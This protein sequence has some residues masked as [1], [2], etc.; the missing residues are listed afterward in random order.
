MISLVLRAKPNEYI[1]LHPTQQD[2]N[3]YP[4]RDGHLVA[5]WQTM[6]EAAAGLTSSPLLIPLMTIFDVQFASMDEVHAQLG[7]KQLAMVDMTSEPPHLPFNLVY[8][9]SEAE[10]R[11]MSGAPTPAPR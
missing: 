4:F 1:E 11:A 8:E 5:F 9:V 7:G 2:R 10:A 3:L 6:E